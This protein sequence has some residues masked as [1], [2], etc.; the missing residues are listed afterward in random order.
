MLSTRSYS[1]ALA[2]D[3]YFDGEQ[4]AKYSGL[5]CIESQGKTLGIVD[6]SDLS[7]RFIVHHSRLET[8]DAEGVRHIAELKYDGRKLC[9][10]NET[11]KLKFTTKNHG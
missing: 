9:F 2:G 3:P 4:L 11:L 10:D 5:A 8:I 7:E 6:L 1:I